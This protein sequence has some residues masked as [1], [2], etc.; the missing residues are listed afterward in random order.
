[1][2][3]SSNGE[4]DDAIVTGEAP[5]AALDAASIIDG[6]ANN[7]GRQSYGACPMQTR[8]EH[9]R[10]DCIPVRRRDHPLGEMAHD[11]HADKGGDQDFDLLE[12]RT[13]Q[14]QRCMS[15]D[16]DDDHAGK[17]D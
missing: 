5:L 8:N 3:S 12:A 11:N 4:A 10:R 1:M 7:A 17:P 16:P 9:I 14:P 15:V 2:P 13:L 6:G